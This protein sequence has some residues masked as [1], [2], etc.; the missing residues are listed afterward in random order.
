MVVA[1]VVVVMVAGCSSSKAVARLLAWYCVAG[2]TYDGSHGRA[3]R[4]PQP[5]V[6]LREH[7]EQVVIHLGPSCQLTAKKSTPV[8]GEARKR[9]Q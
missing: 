4:A 8:Q 9:E 7:I 2:D 5:Q 3:F 1:V 6:A